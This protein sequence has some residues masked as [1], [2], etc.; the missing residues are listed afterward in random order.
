MPD[1]EDIYPGFKPAIK[2]TPC[3]QTETLEERSTRELYSA[4][5]QMS[6]LLDMRI[7]GGPLQDDLYLFSSEVLGELH[8]RPDF[9]EVSRAGKGRL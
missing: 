9:D 4:Y 5:Q 1:N 3:D 7:L 6:I 2:L 8:A